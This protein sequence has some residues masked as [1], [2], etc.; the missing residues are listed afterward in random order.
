MGKVR[1][2]FMVLA[3]KDLVRLG[4]VKKV[5]EKRKEV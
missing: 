2:C 4:D 3:K 5:R 1:D